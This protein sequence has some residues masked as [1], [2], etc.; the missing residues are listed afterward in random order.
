MVQR[1]RV[2]IKIPV[3][4]LESLQMPITPVSR[5]LTL[6]LVCQELP[7]NV[8]CP[9]PI[10]KNEN[11]TDLKNNFHIDVDMKLFWMNEI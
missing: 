3:P 4:M 9:L 1:L 7:T 5:D 10:F 2:L 6:C 11:K 8:A